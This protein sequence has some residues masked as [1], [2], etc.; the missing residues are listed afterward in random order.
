MWALK[1][2]NWTIRCFHCSS[3]PKPHPL[4]NS[5]RSG[6]VWRKSFPHCWPDEP[7]GPEGVWSIDKRGGGVGGGSGRGLQGL[8]CQVWAIN[9]PVLLQ[10]CPSGDRG[11]QL[12]LYCTSNSDNSLVLSPWERQVWSWWP[13][14]IQFLFKATPQTHRGLP[15]DDTK[16]HQSKNCNVLY[17]RL[18]TAF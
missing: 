14:D 8:V 11:V 10:D 3:S 18:H 2:S 17:Q 9:L 15:K 4:W 7:G 16:S 6:K 13:P 1:K 5:Y 12:C